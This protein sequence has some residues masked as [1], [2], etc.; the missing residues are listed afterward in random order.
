MGSPTLSTPPS[1]LANDNRSNTSNNNQHA[2]EQG[3]HV[4][5]N[6]PT[7]RGLYYSNKEVST[8]QRQ[9]SQGINNYSQHRHSLSSLPDEEDEINWDHHRR[10]HSPRTLSFGISSTSTP[11]QTTHKSIKTLSAD[12]GYGTTRQPPAIP[13]SS[14]IPLE[15]VSLFDQQQHCPTSTFQESYHASCTDDEDDSGIDHQS[16][17]TSSPIGPST[18]PPSSN[19]TIGKNGKSSI[20]SRLSAGLS[21]GKKFSLRQKT[22][23]HMRYQEWTETRLNTSTK[24]SVIH[25]F[26]PSEP[27]LVHPSVSS[28]LLSKP[29]KHHPPPSNMISLATEDSATEQQQQPVLD[30]AQLPPCEAITRRKST[31]NLEAQKQPTIDRTPSELADQQDSLKLIDTNGQVIGRYVRNAWKQSPDIHANL[32]SFSFIETW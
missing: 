11:P 6:I 17:Y 19:D 26:D 13:T 31:G 1:S 12:S 9:D 32:L 2:T 10:P 21:L 29:S 30:I 25:M 3:L 28:P 18:P 22:P 5:N 24:P 16:V 4:G 14:H 8:H 27:P 23:F 7:E 15:L 20:S